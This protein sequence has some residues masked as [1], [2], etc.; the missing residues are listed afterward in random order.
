MSQDN[1]IDTL[2]AMTPD[3]RRQAIEAAPLPAN[4]GH[5]LDQAAADA[6]DTLAW[7]FFETGETIT[8]AELVRAVNR[9]AN[10]LRAWGVTRGAHVAVMLP[11]CPQM[12]TIWLALARLG[13]VMVPVNVRYTRRELR[14]ILDDSEAGFLILHSDFAALLAATAD[15]TAPLSVAADRIALFGGRAEGFAGRIWE[16]EVRGHAETFAADASIGHG[17]LMNIQYTSGTTGFPK[18]CMLTHRYWLSAS[19]VNGLRDGKRYER[20]LAST[21]FFYLDP[22]WLLL[23][24]FHHR[25]TLYV[26]QRQSASRFAGWL[27]EHRIN[28]C[29]FPEVVFK[30]PA[31]PDDG[32]SYLRRANIYGVRKEIHPE[33]RQR[34]SVPAMEAFG[35]TETGPT[36]FVPLE[37]TQMIGSGSCGVPTAFRECRVVDEAGQDVPR[38]EIGEL[39][40]RGPGM[41]LGYY[42]KPEANEA[43][44]FGDWFRT[45]DLFRQDENGF[46][47]IVGRLKDMVRRAGENIAAREVEAVLK[48]LPDVHDAAVIAVPDDLRG[49]EVKA[50]VVLQPH[51]TAGVPPTQ[52]IFDHCSRNLAAFKVPRYLEFV[53][54]LPKTPSE[55]IAKSELIRAKSDLRVGAYDRV[56]GLWR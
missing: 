54:A 26:A 22:Q 32:T 50:Y 2:A 17:D 42:K 46:F 43:S 24:A 13:A 41:M 44:Y 5:L 31:C 28:F 20:V 38:G 10:A 27:R 8:Y 36:L 6:G 12:P 19:K 25:G 30:Q 40:V 3:Q 56:D 34:F 53:D 18:G 9:T 1:F 4:I 11:N 45:G 39:V 49:Q 37:A 29:L 16:D 14:Y 15:D 7:N 23:L 48:N 35:M 55:K 33:L 21:P 47:Y 51:A 52:Q